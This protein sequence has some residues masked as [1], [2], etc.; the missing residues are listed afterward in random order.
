MFRLITVL[1][2]ILLSYNGFS[3]KYRDADIFNSYFKNLDEGEFTGTI[4][5]VLFVER[6]GNELIID[7]QG[8]PSSLTVTPDL[9]E[10]YDSSTKKYLGESTNGNSN[11][12]YSTYAMANEFKLK[13]G[14]T[15]YGITA[16]DGAAD[17]V[18]NGID[19]YYQA[20]ANTEYLV[21]TFSKDLAIDNWRFLLDNS[22]EPRDIQEL[23]KK[24]LNLVI[25]KN[26]TL[27]FAIK[28]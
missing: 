24:K 12:S 16:I 28:K 3:Q 23:R 7:F 27:T 8:S 15:G 19:Y 5:G 22:V 6:E 14:N 21:L 9:N 26:S 1:N 13:I 17:M 11:V 20:E 10:V 18:I 25:K 4:N 2:L